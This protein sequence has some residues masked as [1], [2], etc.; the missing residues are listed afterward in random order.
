[1]KPILRKAIPEVEDSFIVRRDIGD[2]MINN[3][4]YHTECEI[5]YIKKSAGTWIVGDYEGKFESGDLILLGSGIPHSYQHEEKYIKNNSDETGEALVTIFSPQIFGDS[6][7]NLPESREIKDLLALSKRGVKIK[8]AAKKEVVKLIEEIGCAKKG[9]KLIALLD[10]LQCI[11]ESN[12]YELL[13]TEGYSVQ[14]ENTNNAKL[15]AVIDYTY[16]NYHNQITI[17]EVAVLINLSVHS[18]CRFFKDKTKKTYIQFL[19]EVRIGKACKYLLEHDMSSAEVGYI[20]G[21]NSISHFNHQFKVMK[22]KSPLAFK[23]SYM[24]LLAK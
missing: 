23:K 1:M 15:N 8:N 7:L 20:C 3:W 2:K 22:N 9:R 24:G 16:S 10:I 18:F 14:K 6:F 19:M 21:Y 17:E 13:A 5:V 11:T 12:D 4:H